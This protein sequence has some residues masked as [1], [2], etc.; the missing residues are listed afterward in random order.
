MVTLKQKIKNNKKSKNIKFKK[1][2]F[3]FS[4]TVYFNLISSLL[5]FS[6][7]QIF[8]L[9]YIYKKKRRENTKQKYK[10]QFQNKAPLK[11]PVSHMNL[12]VALKI[13]WFISTLKF[14]CPKRSISERT[15][16][17]SGRSDMSS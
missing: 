14:E 12:T 2:F 1:I 4:F 10:E 5:F 9:Q 11:R 13:S 16:G 6:L 15:L 17:F 8:Y 7:G 3:T